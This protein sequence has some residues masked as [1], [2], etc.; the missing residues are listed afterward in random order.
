ANP[1][2]VDAIEFNNTVARKRYPFDFN[3]LTTPAET[4]RLREQFNAFLRRK[5]GSRAGLEAA[6]TE[7]PL[8]KWEDPAAG[9]ILIPTNFRGQDR[10]EADTQTRRADP[11]VSDVIEFTCEIQREWATDVARFLRDD[12]G[13]K[14]AIGWNGDTFHVAQA[15]NHLANMEAPLDLAVGAAYLDS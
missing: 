9:T 8:F 11:R 1:R 6:W 7:D 12:V 4:R 10:Y 13:L 14:C 5:Y 15:P 3:N 2:I